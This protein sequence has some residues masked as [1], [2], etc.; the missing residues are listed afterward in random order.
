MTGRLLLAVGLVLTTALALAWG[1]GDTAQATTF[2]PFFGPPDFYRL[3]P[4]TMGAYPDVHAQFN[5]LPPS[6]N[7]SPHFG[8]LISFG[9]SHIYVADA[10]GI[11]GTGAYV[12][13]LQSTA[14]LGLANEGC[15][16]QV[17][18]TFELVEASTDTTAWSIDTPP[19]DGNRA[20]SD[21]PLLLNSAITSGASTLVYTGASGTDP[22]GVRA[23]GLPVT[24]SRSV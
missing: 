18:V 17:P 12:G 19:G 9:D 7:V 10:A 16:S 11:P 24:A 23:D 3:D 4:T 5:I 15:N 1:S 21:D 8:G 13:R 20:T 22:L 2:N 6:A 14:T